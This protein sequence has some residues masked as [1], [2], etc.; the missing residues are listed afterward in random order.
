[1]FYDRV[2]ELVKAIDYRGNYYKKVIVPLMEEFNIAERIVYKRVKSY[3]GCTITQLAQKNREPSKEEIDKAL[4]TSSNPTEMREMLG[5]KTT[6]KLWV[7]LFDRT[8][9]TSNFARAKA[10]LELRVPVQEYNPTK[11][12]NLSLIASQAIGDGHLDRVRKA[13]SIA[14][15]M[16]QFDYL[17]VKVGLF[18]RAFPESSG[19]ENIR[20]HT[21]TQ[22]HKYC[23]WYSKR[24]PNKYVEKLITLR[25][26]E[27]VDFL[28]PLGLFLLYMDDGCYLANTTGPQSLTF[29]FPEKYPE[30]GKAYQ[31]HLSTY[32]FDF[33]FRKNHVA[34]NSIPIIAKFINNMLLPFDSL[35]PDCM[36]YKVGMK[37]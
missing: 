16:Q 32:G 30:L 23:R 27:M 12:D 4:I 2:Q 17:K 8:Y 5:L 22:G 13:L 26:H 6:D 24:L 7:G 19:L 31:E 20:V 29:A 21:H 15:G 25:K 11:D 33:H 14:H 28:T 36:R 35:I 34:I 1:M 10:Q 9:G 37:I 18:N 3:F